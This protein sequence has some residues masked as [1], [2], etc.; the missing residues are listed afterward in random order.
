[1]A[2]ALSAVALLLTGCL[3]LDMALTVSSDDTVSGSMIFAFDKTLLAASGQSAQDA[4]GSQAP[5][6]EDVQ[7]VTS[8]PY[9]DDKFEGIK[10]TF[11]KVPL[12]KLSESS[13]SDSLKIKRVGDEFVVTGA[14]DMSQG[15]D[16]S[17]GDPTMDAQFQDAFKSADI[18]VS[19]TFPGKIVSSN[20]TVSGNTV[21]WVPKLG[22]KTTFEATAKATSGG[23]MM[24]IL[25]IAGVA[26]LV[27]VIIVVVLMSR[28]GKGSVAP[29]VPAEVDAPAAPPV[30]APA[31]DSPP[32]PP[33]TPPT[34]P[35]P[36]TPPES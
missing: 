17:T 8:A 22:E 1:M 15:S 5:F 31:A 18:R 3:K 29:S 7:G 27:V 4:I 16:T 20:G 21:T 25:I 13:D 32:P 26:L 24:M 11:A 34:P 14:M 35:T 30:D 36:A 9:T 23:S 28:K 2:L 33:P 10:Y 6:G 19:I 12:S